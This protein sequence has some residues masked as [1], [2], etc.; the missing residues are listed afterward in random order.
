M[1]TISSVASDS[2]VTPWTAAC[3]ASLSITNF[4]RLLKLTVQQSHPVIPFS[5]CL[6]PFPA[7]GG[8]SI[9]T[10]ASVLPMNIHWNILDWFALGLTALISLQSKGL[11]RVLSDTSALLSSNTTI[12]SNHLSWPITENFLQLEKGLTPGNVPPQNKEN[13]LV[14]RL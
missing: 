5:S 13:V 14:F 12:F 9:G 4:Q 7:S 11:S 8:Q 2:F 6:Q 3:Q 10:L 1:L